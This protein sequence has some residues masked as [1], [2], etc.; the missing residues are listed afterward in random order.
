MYEAGIKESRSAHN[1]SMSQRTVKQLATFTSDSGSDTRKGK[2][3]G[4]IAAIR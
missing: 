1:D 4:M 3:F 2:Q